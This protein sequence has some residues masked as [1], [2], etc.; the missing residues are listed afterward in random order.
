MR[1]WP[2]TA[3]FA[4]ARDGA[5]PLCRTG[6][7]RELR[8]YG[9]GA[10]RLEVSSA[11]EA[12][13]SVVVNLAGRSSA[14]LF[15]DNPAMMQLRPVAKR[16]IFFPRAAMWSRR[17]RCRSGAAHAVIAKQMAGVYIYARYMLGGG[18]DWAVAPA[19]V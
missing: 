6:E 14:F 8:A 18:I 10:R 3:L 17:R 13:L 2:R 11:C 9:E 19:L 5:A 1:A 4:V 15:R 12:V 16:L 7:R